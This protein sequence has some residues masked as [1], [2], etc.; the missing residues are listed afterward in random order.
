MKKI[1][2]GLMVICTLFFMTNASIACDC[3]C[4]N[5]KNT[6]EIECSKDCDCGCQN[7]EECKCNKD[8]AQCP[9]KECCKKCNCGC[10][11]DEK[12][13]CSKSK[14]HKIFKKCKKSKKSCKKGCPLKDIINENAENSE[15]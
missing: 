3:G 10:Q 8:K 7:G 9:K 14:C 6:A 13:K 12:C 1:I 4:Q 11:N 5:A 2:M 15:E